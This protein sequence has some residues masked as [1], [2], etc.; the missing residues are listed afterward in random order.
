MLTADEFDAARRSTQ[1]AHYTSDTIISGIYRGLDRFGFDGGRILEPAAGVG[2]FIGLAP[3]QLRKDSKF[4][5]IELDPLTAS[6]AKHLYPSTSI[7]NKGY[8]DVTI[9][10]EHFDAVVGNPPFGSQSV[11]DARH[12]DLSQF[13]IHN[14]FIA[15]SLDKLR[16]GGV[17]AFVV[18]NF[19]MDAKVSPAR[20]HIADRARL[21][22]AIRLPNNAFK[23]NAL[24]EVTTDIVFF[25]KAAEGE[26][27][28][29][30]WV[31]TV[32]QL[33]QATGEEYP[34]NRYFAERPDMMLG[35]MALVGT[36]YRGGQAALVQRAGSDLGADLARAIDSL[37]ANIYQRSIATNPVAVEPVEQI[38]VPVATKVGAFFVAPDGRI[39]RRTPDLLEDPQYEWVELKNDR[40]GERIRGMVEIRTAVRTLMAA[41]QFESTTDIELERH[42]SQLNRVYDRF[43]KRHGHI[44]SQPNKQAFS[45][46]PEYPL[47]HALERDYDRGISKDV[48]KKTGADPREPSA[49]KAAIFTQRVMSPRREI[50]H[51]ETAKDALVVSMNDVGRVD[52][53]LMARLASKPE[54]EI[55]SELSGL[56]Y[57]NPLLRRWE[58]A[59]QY[60]SGNVKDKLAAAKVAAKLDPK[61]LTNVEALTK[62]LPPDIEPVDI[63]VALSSTWV[64][65]HVISDFVTH[66]LGNVNRNISYQESLG[67]WVARIGAS[68][69]R[70]TMRARWGTEDIPANELI[71]SILT[72]RAIQVREQVGIDEKGPVYQ[73]NEARTA[74]ATQK[75]DEIKQAFIDW[76]WEDRTRRETLARLYN[77]RFNTNVAPR[78][79][80]SHLTLPGSSLGITPRPHQKDAIWRGVQEGSA[81]FD[82]VVG[83]GKTFVCIGAIMESRRMGL[84]K[85]PM[86]VVPNHLVLQWKDSFY[87]LYPNANIL[88]AEKADFAKENRERLFAKIATGNWDAVIVAHSSFKKIGMPQEMLG[89]ILNEQINDLT[90]SIAKLKTESGDKITVKEMEKARDR[91]RAKLERAAETGLKDQAVTFSDLGVDALLVDESHEFKNLFINTT[92]NRVSGLGNLAGSDKAFDLFVKA[93]YVQR[94]NDGRGV[95]FATGTPIS[96]TIAELYTVQRYMQYDELKRRG[97]VHF[98]AWASTFGQVVTGWELDAT[99]VNY[100][101]NS[102]FAKFQNVPELINLY[103]SFADVITKTDLQEQAAAQGTRFPVPRVKGGKPQNV[104]VDRSP[105]QAQ[106]M[107]IQSAQLG[108]DGQQRIRADGT[109]VMDWNPGSIIHRMENLP[110]DPRIDN[111]LKITNDAR[112]AGLDFRLVD[113]DAPDFAGSKTNAAIDRIIDIYERWDERKGTQLVFCDLSTPK[114]IRGA[115]NRPEAVTDNAEDPSVEHDDPDDTPSVSM[116]ELLSRGAK[117]SVYNDIRE[118][119][120]ARGIPADQIRFIHEADTDA[121]KQKLFAAMNRGEVRV[122]LGSTSKMGAGTNVQRRLVALHHL[123]APWRPSDLEQREGRIERQ[124]NLFYE[125]DPDGFEI[126]IYRYAT[127]QTYDSRMW[128]TIEYKAAG[129]E[130]FR[131]GDSLQRVIEDVASESANAAEMKAAATGNPLIFQQVQLSA[132]LKKLEAVYSNFKRSRH[133]LESRVAW[134]ADADKRADNSIA[135]A[136]ME[137][138]IRD[139]NT[140]DAFRFVAGGRTYGKDQNNQV[141]G[142]VLASMKQAIESKSSG[143]T[144]EIRTFPVGQYRGFEVGTYCDRGSIRFQ[145]KGH[146]LY[147]PDNLTYRPED[148][149]KLSGF[150]SRI[151][152]FLG[153]LDTRVVD[154]EERRESEKAEYGRARDE[155]KKPFPQQ[156]QLEMLRRDAADVLTE[157]KKVQ[158]DPNYVS[159]WVPLSQQPAN[160]AHAAIQ[161]LEPEIAI[162]EAAGPLLHGPTF[163]AP[164][165]FTDVPAPEI[166]RRADQ[167]VKDYL[168]AAANAELGATV[169]ESP[170]HEALFKMEDAPAVHQLL[171]DRMRTDP[172]LAQAV[173]EYPGVDYASPR[174]VTAAEQ[175]IAEFRVAVR[176]AEALGLHATPADRQSGEYDGPVIAQAGEYVLQ[177]IGIN[178]CIAHLK[179]DFIRAAPQTS[180]RGVTVRYN[181]GIAIERTELQRGGMSR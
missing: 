6:I 46:D 28:D 133:A 99:G 12:T 113:A 71:T 39:A 68:S 146:H 103:R 61:Y 165:V 16:T 139:K 30:S 162:P 4:T 37:P 125:Q 47:L 122:L 62:V 145:L 102:R 24:T 116:D 53:D 19:F 179:S 138:A 181:H 36:M 126:E 82:H 149:F 1:D 144:E 175:A 74:A 135:N 76:V 114:D 70:T 152:N 93:R 50:T 148:D 18:S 121:K 78:Y 111:P 115:T 83:A 176:A 167:A 67:K 150:F 75:A 15:K 92:M 64:P 48:A 131:R 124:G 66:L 69:D 166:I 22:G 108:E 59:D 38:E 117:F 94:M 13:S 97:I 154:A 49:K 104:I 118:K 107:G 161:P 151:D 85:K 132:D 14:Y 35:E 87:E 55:V 106:Y 43:V 169:H 168:T 7:I 100:K 129:I 10:G 20:E 33:D 65:E 141:H 123:D 134:L 21:L 142:L 95:F 41:E 91:M 128:Q 45:D 29:K 178:Q 63:S 26:H 119:L 130:Q 171:V 158:A 110:D 153:K 77:D 58:T 137:I 177:K 79:D 72:G 159:S 34:L 5:A 156:A 40:A 96:N 60:L 23:Q 80:G 8:Q 140:T 86:V 88:V 3:E 27:L 56:I 2:H 73:I 120:I 51:V 90:T 42:R 172:L 174:M 157:L 127:K 147:S 101:L 31:E 180:L 17:A 57:R 81:L 11:Y 164:V 84:M 136:R 52:M 32:T 98:D 112:K 143:S 105:M 155:L 160:A 173:T 54:E 44:S 170:A 163:A 25:Q 109:N 89:E 9:P